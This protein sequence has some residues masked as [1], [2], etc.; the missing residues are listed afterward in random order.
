MIFTTL[1]L[2]SQIPTRSPGKAMSGLE[3]A[4]ILAS[5]WAAFTLPTS[6]PSKARGIRAC[7][8]SAVTSQQQT[9]RSLSLLWLSYPPSV[10]L[11]ACLPDCL[12]VSSEIHSVIN[13]R[14][15]FLSRQSPQRFLCARLGLQLS[16]CQ[17]RD[18][19]LKA[20]S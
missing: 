16:G 6:V 5:P 13:P 14:E 12:S 20:L 19:T 1:S 4:A 11:S 15:L 2:S 8:E 3:T 17:G 7:K 9:S 10:R 18:W